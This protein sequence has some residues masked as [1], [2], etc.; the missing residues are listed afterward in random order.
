MPSVENKGDISNAAFVIGDD[1]IAVIDT[2]YNAKMGQYLH[3]L[4]RTVSDRPI[5]Y[6]INT[7]MHLDHVFGNVA[8]RNDSTEFI[9]HH[10]FSRGLQARSRGYLESAADAVGPEIMAG[11][12][13]VLPNRTVKDELVLDLGGRTLLLKTRPTAHTDNDMTVFD[14]KTKTLILGDLLFVEHIPTL[15]GSVLGWLKLV[16]VLKNEKADRAVPGHGPAS[17]PWPA[18]IDPLKQYFEIVSNEVRKMIEE[19][20]TI[21]Y[22]S[23]NVAQKEKE[24]WL[25]HDEFHGRNVAAAFAELEW[26]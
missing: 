19:G 26:E 3:D 22:A 24:S 13:M 17:V 23:S 18:A 20:Q 7:H 16:E 4:I 12:E 1:A 21:A 14:N 15:D 8:F 5:K 6:V 2:S 10:K 11:T 9:A 25:L